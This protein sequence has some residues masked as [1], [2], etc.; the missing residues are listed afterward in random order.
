M[1]FIDGLLTRRNASS[2]MAQQ[3]LLGGVLSTVLIGSLGQVGFTADKAELTNSSEQCSSAGGVQLVECQ[4]ISQRVDGLRVVGTQADAPVVQALLDKVDAL[5]TASND[6]DID[7][8]V[9]HFSPGFISGDN[10]SLRDM[11]RLIEETWELYPDITYSLKPI[12]LRV[13]GNWA[14]IET[15]DKAEATVSTES[16]KKAALSGDEGMEEPMLFPNEQGQLTTHS[17][18][19]LYLHKV[20]KS[21]EI[22]SDRSLYETAA[23]LYGEAKNLPLNLSAPDQVF[24][25]ETYTARIDAD[26]P[27]GGVAIASITRHAIQYPPI[28]GEDKFRSVTPNKSR[29]ERVFDANELS[30]NELITAVIGLTEVGQDDNNRPT[31]AFKGMATLTK[32]VNV[33]PKSMGGDNQAAVQLVKRSADG[34]IDLTKS[35]ADNNAS[36]ESSDSE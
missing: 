26:I 21:W 17:R 8:V 11:R 22:T 19:M 5:V 34:Q 7:G 20:G 30:K 33:S 27:N 16:P 14:T 23:I 31:V 10:L 1:A 24:A 12:E 9:R 2:S 29:L 25:G 28:S 32:R 6:H 36:K 35:A 13:N 3:W 15:V 4:Q 18:G